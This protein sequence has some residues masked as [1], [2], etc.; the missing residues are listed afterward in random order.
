MDALLTYTLGHLHAL[1]ATVGGNAWPLS[2]ANITITAAILLA[3][4]VQAP[5]HLQTHN[6]QWL[7]Q[8]TLQ[9]VRL[10]PGAPVRLHHHDT[11][12]SSLLVR[13]GCNLGGSG[14]DPP[15]PGHK[16][17][18]D[19]APMVAACR[20]ARFWELSVGVLKHA[21][22]QLT[23][24]TVRLKPGAPVQLPQYDTATSSLLVRDGCNLGGVVR[25]GFS[26]PPGH[27][28]GHELTILGH[29]RR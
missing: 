10:K 18:H 13:D 22:M 5:H 27:K 15:P 25:P 4:W 2:S 7:M 29:K 17:G 20:S 8:L 9:T 26:P 3:W 28:K 12:I 1:P 21:A 23:L 19:Q 24:Q 11:V 6:N 14:L 16:K